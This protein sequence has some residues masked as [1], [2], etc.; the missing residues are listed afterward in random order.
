MANVVGLIAAVPVGLVLAVPIFYAR[1]R[2]MTSRY[3]SYA[4]PVKPRP[5]PEQDAFSA[6]LRDTED[7]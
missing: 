6:Y 1:S 7:H 2:W 4:E 3:G 5:A